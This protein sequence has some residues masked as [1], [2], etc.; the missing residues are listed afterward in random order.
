MAEEM[1]TRQDI[2]K[3]FGVKKATVNRWV[4]YHEDFPK[5]VAT[6]RHPGRPQELF[7]PKAV[8]DWVKARRDRRRGGFAFSRG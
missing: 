6:R 3:H 8:K 7:E 4:F 5:P 1:W 2:A